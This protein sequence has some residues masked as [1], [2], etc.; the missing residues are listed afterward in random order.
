MSNRQKDQWINKQIKTNASAVDQDFTSRVSDL[1][2]HSSFPDRV[3]D[4]S[5]QHSDLLHGGPGL[6]EWSGETIGERPP[7]SADIWLYLHPHGVAE[8]QGVGGLEREIPGWKH[9]ANSADEWSFSW[10]LL[11]VPPWQTI[12]DLY[13][14]NTFY[15]IKKT[16]LPDDNL[17]VVKNHGVILCLQAVILPLFS[18]ELVLEVVCCQPELQYIHRL[19]LLNILQRK[20]QLWLLDGILMIHASHLSFRFASSD[21]AFSAR[22]S[23]TCSCCG[24]WI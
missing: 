22:V 24:S 12:A 14:S 8:A 18:S 5:F 11:Q 17:L 13:L 2:E 21:E 3:K 7:L 16:N 1:S 19:L 15:T 20:R 10:L 6:S 9:K 4:K 23:F